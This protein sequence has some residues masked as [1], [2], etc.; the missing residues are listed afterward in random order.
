[1]AEARRVAL[2]TGGARGIGR[3]T[4]ARLARDGWRVVVADRQRASPEHPASRCVEVDVSDEAAVGALLDGVP[5]SVVIGVSL[6]GGGGVSLVA[7]AAVFLSN[8]PE[9]MSSAAGMRRAGRSAGYV[10]GV[11]A[12]SRWRPGSRRWW[13]TSPW[14][15]RARR[16]TPG[17]RGDPGRNHDT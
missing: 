2:V 8:V 14:P 9:G 3:A 13:A 12:A 5:E 16:S 11:W 1:M 17:R 15:A 7:V 6:P 10:S 4:A